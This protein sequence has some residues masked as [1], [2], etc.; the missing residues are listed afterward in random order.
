MQVILTEDIVKLFFF[1]WLV[2]SNSPPIVP[3]EEPDNQTKDHNELGETQALIEAPAQPMLKL[4][5]FMPAFPKPV[6]FI[7]LNGDS[8]D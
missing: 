7:L 5:P 8:T 2:M 1:F 4:I 3:L 6:Y